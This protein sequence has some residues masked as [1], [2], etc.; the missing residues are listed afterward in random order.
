VNRFFFALSLVATSSLSAQ[1]RIP[2]VIETSAGA[3][4][5]ELD[6]AH[7]PI[8]VT[9]FIRYM[10]AHLL[11]NGAFFRAVTMANQPNNVV[12]IEVIQ[13]RP[14]TARRGRGFPPIVLER[15]NVTGL[16]HHDGTLS[17]A[18]S[19]TNSATNQFFVTIGEQPELDFGGKRNA[20]GQGFA[21]FG[22]VTKG[23]DI[24]RI[25]QS[26]AVNGQN[27]LAPVTIIRVARR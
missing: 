6:S 14:D 24:V 16:K 15:T 4:E 27:L 25:I 18:R 11:D 21:A 23:M 9:N 1:G 5:A 22:Q 12:K 7:A 26:G 17:M 10:D 13:S 2:I 19:D 8:T 3:I 20:D